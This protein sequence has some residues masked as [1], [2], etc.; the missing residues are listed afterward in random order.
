MKVKEHKEPDYFLGTKRG[1]YSENKTHINISV[2][3]TAVIMM[4]MTVMVIK[5]M[6]YIGIWL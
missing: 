1:K 6:I 3:Y 4:V 5:M 2:H